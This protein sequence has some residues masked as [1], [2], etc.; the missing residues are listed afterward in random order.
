MSKALIR[1]KEGKVLNTNDIKKSLEKVGLESGDIIMMH[2]GL[3]NIGRPVIRAREELVSQIVQVVFEIIGEKGTLIV[4]TFTYSFCMDKPFDKENSSSNSPGQPSVMGVISEEV[5]KMEDSH[6]SLHPIFSVAALGYRAE[7]LTADVGKTSF[8]KDSIFDTLTRIPQSKFLFLGVDL[9]YLTF[10]HYVEKEM[11]VEYR[12][13]KEFTGKIIDGERE[14]TDTYEYFVRDLEHDV[15]TNL[16]DFQEYLDKKGIL[17]STSLGNN[18][19]YMLPVREA[20]YH[21]KKL[22]AKDKNFFIEGVY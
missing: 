7:E 15:E 17:N 19:V 14:Y 6:R 5:R 8:G 16:A 11:E 2:S 3:I 22:I 20:E 13:P 12:Y 18:T 21:I 10:L 1:T 4:P 9:S